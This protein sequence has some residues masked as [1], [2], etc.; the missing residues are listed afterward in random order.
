[1]IELERAKQIFS[2]KKLFKKGKIAMVN[3]RENIQ[4]EYVGNLSK[5][6]VWN[7]TFWIKETEYNQRATVDFGKWHPLDAKAGCFDI[8][9]EEFLLKIIELCKK[10]EL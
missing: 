8:C 10:G 1:M 2:D 4:V 7:Y 9:D 3:N 6:G 5:D